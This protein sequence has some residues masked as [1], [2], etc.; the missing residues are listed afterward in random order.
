MFVIVR[1][2]ESLARNEH[3]KYQKRQSKSAYIVENTVT[4]TIWLELT[5]I[6]IQF[7]YKPLSITTDDDLGLR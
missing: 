6:Q 3:K 2:M 4:T 5:D 7:H 1:L